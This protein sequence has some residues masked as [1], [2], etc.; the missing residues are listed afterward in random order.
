MTLY[1][2]IRRWNDEP[3]RT[4]RDVRQGVYQQGHIQTG[5]GHTH[6][7]RGSETADSTQAHDDESLSEAEPS[8]LSRDGGH[9]AG[10]PGQHR[11]GT[12]GHHDYAT[13]EAGLS[14]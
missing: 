1:Y 11:T 8:R 3:G 12:A 2:H 14:P 4:G 6:D 10:H 7:R 5:N 9:E 13:G